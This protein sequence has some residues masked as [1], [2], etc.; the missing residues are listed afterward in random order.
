M[1]VEVASSRLFN[2]D[3]VKWIEFILHMRHRLLFFE[4]AVRF[5]TTVQA[6]A[7]FIAGISNLLVIGFVVAFMEVWKHIFVT[8]AS[9][10]F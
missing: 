10:P 3:V 5:L 4:V 1:L 6:F 8:R 9:L 7:Y 2:Q